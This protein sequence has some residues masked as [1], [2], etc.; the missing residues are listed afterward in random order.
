MSHAPPLV[1]TQASSADL[2]TPI[3]CQS[4]S[5]LQ[6]SPTLLPRSQSHPSS[7]LGSRAAWHGG[8]TGC[9]S[10]GL[11]VSAELSQ[12][13]IWV[14]KA[15]GTGDFPELC[16]KLLG[17]IPFS[18]GNTAG[19]SRLCMDPHVFPLNVCADSHQGSLAEGWGHRHGHS[20]NLM[21]IWK[22]RLQGAGDTT[23]EGRVGAR[24]Q[25][26]N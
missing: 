21:K 3:S 7:H 11:W 26:L 5:Q 8:Y 23:G 14:E 24:I 4:S 15:A 16:R 18:R 19:T 1:T 9:S 12:L 10:R 6:P 25:N 2:L 22:E 20:M 17:L 13:R